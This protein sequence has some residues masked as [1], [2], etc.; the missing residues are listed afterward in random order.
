[1]IRSISAE[2][3]VETVCLSPREVEV[4]RLLCYG[5]TQK[6]IA[7]AMGVS[8]HTVNAQLRRIGMGTRIPGRHLVAWVLQRPKVLE[9]FP[10]PLPLHPEDCQCDSP[11]CT[12]M[13]RGREASRG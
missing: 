9:R 3:E 2:G 6:E 7:D 1:M 10:V 11:Y 12:A 13:R 8:P 5:R 4:L